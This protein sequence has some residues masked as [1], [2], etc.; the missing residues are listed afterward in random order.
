MFF[1]SVLDALLAPPDGRFLRRMGV[2]SAVSLGSSMAL[3]GTA[4]GLLALAGIDIDDLEAPAFG[5][6]IGD[7]VI[8]VLLAPIIETLLLIVLLALMPSRW[9]IVTRATLSALVWGCLHALTAP[10]WFLGVVV[11]FFVF[12]CGY[13]VWRRESFGLGFAAAALPHTLQNLAAFLMIVLAG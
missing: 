11:P 3:V 1:R 2:S 10:F 7:F 5:T 12:S 8:L 4:V 9:S 13:L 6:G